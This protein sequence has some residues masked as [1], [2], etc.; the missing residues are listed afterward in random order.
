MAVGKNITWKKGKQYHLP[1][2]IEAVEEYQAGKRTKILGKKIKIKNWDG[3]EYPDVRNYIHFC[4]DPPV[5]SLL[6]SEYCR[7]VEGL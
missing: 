5:S 4:N 3:E 6:E 1:Y 2:H 7:H